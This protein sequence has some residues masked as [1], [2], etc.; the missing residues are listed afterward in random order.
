MRTPGGIL[1]VIVSSLIF[2]SCNKNSNPVGTSTS[3]SIPTAGLLAYFPLNGNANDSS[4]HG[5]NGT[6]NGG[7]TWV[8]DRFGHP[9]SACQLNGTNASISIP[10][11]TLALNFNVKTQSYT[12]CCWVKLDSL[13]YNRDM[14]IIMDRGTQDTQPTSYDLMYRGTTRRF[15]ADTW[16]DTNNIIVPSVTM[17]DTNKWYFLT[18]VADTQKIALYVNGVRELSDIGAVS[19]DSIPSNYGSTRNTETVRTIGDFYPTTVNGHHYFDGAIDGVRI[20]DSA[21]T[22]E[23]ILALYHQNGW[24]PE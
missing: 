1:F 13:P 19:P 14:E 4:G 18:M 10:D 6:I 24:D 3:T 7:V 11:P 16:D 23:E 9:G 17:P 15:V 8:A 12:I 2:L 20:Y 21:L 22:Y 5:H